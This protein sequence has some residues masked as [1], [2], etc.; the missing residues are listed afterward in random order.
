MH[1]AAEGGEDR[2]VSLVQL[3]DR[4]RMI[5]EELERLIVE[6]GETVAKMRGARISHDGGDDRLGGDRTMEHRRRPEAG[7]EGNAHGGSTDA[8][9]I[10]ELFRFPTERLVIIGMLRNA[11]V[12]HAHADVPGRHRV[13]KPVS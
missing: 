3:R 4:R 7:R 1:T 8:L 10:W 12:V 6:A 13:E 5:D 2:G 11:E 9:G